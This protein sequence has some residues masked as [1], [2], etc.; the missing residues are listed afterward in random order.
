MIKNIILKLQKF[1]PSFTETGVIKSSYWKEKKVMWSEKTQ[2]W[3]VSEFCCTSCCLIDPGLIR[4]WAYASAPLGLSCDKFSDPITPIAC[5]PCK[6]CPGESPEWNWDPW[7]NP[8]FCLGYIQKCHC[9]R[10]N[11]YHLYYFAGSITNVLN[12]QLETEATD[13]ID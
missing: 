13:S 12:N 8:A 4:C 1:E 2:T 7:A 3:E 5:I 10:K 9:F 6:D 11:R